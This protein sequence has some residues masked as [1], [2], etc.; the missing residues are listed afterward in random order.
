[1]LLSNSKILKAMHLSKKSILGLLA[2]LLVALF[3]IA[4]AITATSAF[5]LLNFFKTTITIHVL[6]S[7]L[8]AATTFINYRMC[9]YAVPEMLIDMFGFSKPFQGLMQ[10]EDGRALSSKRKAL[11]VLAVLLAFAVGIVFASLN[12]YGTL[13]I[14]NKLSA[15]GTYAIISLLT[16]IFA[17]VMF[18]CLSALMLRSLSKL[19]KT[20]NVL[21][22]CQIRLYD[23]ID[24]NPELPR[25][26][27][28]SHRLIIAE[29][30]TTLI[31]A[32]ITLPLAIIGL[33][34][35]IKTCNLRFTALLLNIH[36]LAPIYITIISK[37][38]FGLALMGQAPFVIRTS[39]LT[40]ASCFDNN[41]HHHTRNQR[42]YIKTSLILFMRFIYAVGNGLI[43]MLGSNETLTR[44]LA[45]AGS[46]GYSF[47]ATA[48][49]PS[50]IL[51][52]NIKSLNRE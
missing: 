33:I 51:K 3:S 24:A 5:L 50:A 37:I 10:T 14:I 13:I 21:I 26:K 7:I 15:L 1:M 31:F 4:G 49:D 28:K 9:Q 8:F 44:I 39:F 41:E 16:F 17:F 38:S 6:A 46:T 27:G 52:K 25:N 35:M 30:I 20:E 36:H 22:Q 18:A 23:I 2:K 11:M 34:M 32:I 43:S 47:A 12:Y 45:G 48:H 19:I 40:I 29:R 42:S